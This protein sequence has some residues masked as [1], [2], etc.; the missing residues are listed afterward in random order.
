MSDKLIKPDPTDAKTLTLHFLELTNNELNTPNIQR[1]IV[2]VK[3][4]LAKGYTVEQITKVIDHVLERTMIYSFGYI[5]KVID[6]VLAEINEKEEQER[7]KV[8]AEA[9][10][11]QQE[12]SNAERRGKVDE[13]DESTE[14]NR[15]KAGKFGVQSRLGK[16]FDF[17]MFEGQ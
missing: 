11:R 17:D 4:V 16:K 2:Q 12:Q 14:R 8:L 10:I 3:G 13:F 9:A 5:A 15:N 7:T 6:K 1:T